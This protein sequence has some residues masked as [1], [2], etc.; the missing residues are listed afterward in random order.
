MQAAGTGLEVILLMS[1]PCF[2]AS[3]W[4]CLPWGITSNLTLNGPVNPDFSQVEADAAQFTFDPR[5]TLFV[6]V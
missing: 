5:Q 4:R 2:P 6:A 1:P 3:C